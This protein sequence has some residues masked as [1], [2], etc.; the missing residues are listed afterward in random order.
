MRDLNNRV[1]TT[2]PEGY[3]GNV[4]SYMDPNT[5]LGR[6]FYAKRARIFSD[7]GGDDAL[8]E[9]MKEAIQ[10]FCLFSSMTGSI[11]ARMA[12]HEPVDWGGWVAMQ[13]LKD[14]L[15]KRI[16]MAK[17]PRPGASLSDVMRKSA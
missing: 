11:A 3:L 12:K 5:A 2:I 9:I 13:R 1:V 4:E 16:G 7:L 8:S 17:K 10:D 15:G 14:A 6:A